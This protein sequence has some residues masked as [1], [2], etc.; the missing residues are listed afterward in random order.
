MIM[1]RTLLLAMVF[2]ICCACIIRAQ[3]DIRRDATVNAVEMVMPSVV[4]I[5]TKSTEVVHDPIE[6]FRRQMLGQQ[7]Y[8]EY[9]SVGSGVVID[10][11]GYLLTN[12][13]VVSGADQ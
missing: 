11:S 2:C 3:E 9:I 10:E 7:P 6:R 13:H 1:K 8:D 4:N 5:A 12:D